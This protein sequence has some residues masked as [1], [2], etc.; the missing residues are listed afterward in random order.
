MLNFLEAT[1]YT[2]ENFRL[3]KQP[4]WRECKRDSEPSETSTLTVALQRFV[5]YRCIKICVNV[6]SKRMQS[7]EQ[8]IED[9]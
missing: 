7:I 4:C 2:E 8:V 6:Y 3:Q 9:L 1:F 5:A